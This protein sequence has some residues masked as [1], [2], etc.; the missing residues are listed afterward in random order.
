MGA[1]ADGE[2]GVVTWS[3][4]SLPTDLFYDLRIRATFPDEE[5][6][7][8]FPFVQLCGAPA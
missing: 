3:G 5:V 1:S 6:R 7:L 4:G 2:P 8:T